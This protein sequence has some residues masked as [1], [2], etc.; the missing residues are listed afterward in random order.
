MSDQLVV[1]LEARGALRARVLPD[2]GVYH[3]VRAEVGSL[4]ER[5]AAV[6]TW[7]RYVQ[8]WSVSWIFCDFNLFNR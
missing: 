4:L 2:T 1:A 6:W 8:T 3:Q 7:M 5:L